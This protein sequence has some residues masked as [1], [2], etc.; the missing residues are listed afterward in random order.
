MTCFLELYL[1]QD[2]VI[3]SHLKIFTGFRNTVTTSLSL[4]STVTAVLHT[5]FGNFGTSPAFGSLG[6]FL[7]GEMK[8]NNEI[9]QL[10]FSTIVYVFST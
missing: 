2:N 4:P 5:Q 10:F 3:V 1:R 9:Y 8:V 7:K 6:L